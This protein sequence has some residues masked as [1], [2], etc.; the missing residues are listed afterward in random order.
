MDYSGDDKRSG[1]GSECDGI[2]PVHD[3]VRSTDLACFKTRKADLKILEN[4]MEK[5][6]SKWLIGVITTVSMG[7]IIIIVSM[8][9]SKMKDVH[10][11]VKDLVL[12]VERLTERSNNI[13]VKQQKIA[14][15]QEYILQDMV[16][17]QESIEK[18]DRESQ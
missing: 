5:F 7:L 11:D 10:Q 4:R 8:S 13:M 16:K 15:T 1:T 12:G 9:G 14:T 6:V 3:E 18:H 2:C 17:I